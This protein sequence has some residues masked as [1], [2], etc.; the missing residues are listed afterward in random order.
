MRRSRL[1]RT[2]T[3]LACSAGLAVYGAIGLAAA[4]VPAQ[5]ATSSPATSPPATSPP[6]AHQAPIV[7]PPHVFEPYIGPS[8]SLTKTARAAGVKYFTL[9]FLQTAKPGSC[10]VDWNG[11]PR[12]PVGRPYA[13]GHRR[14]AGRAAARWC[15]SFG[16]ASADSD[17]DRAGRQLPQRARHRRGQYEKVITTYHLT[18]LDLDTEENSLNNYAGIDRRNKAYAM[19]ER[20]AAGDRAAWSSSCT[21]SRPTRPVSTRAAPYV[22]QNA[23]ANGATIADR[24]RDD[25]RLLRQPAARDRR[26]DHRGRR[27]PQLYNRAA[28]CCTRGKTVG[29]AVGD[30]RGHRGLGGGDDLGPAETLAPGRHPHEWRG[31]GD[32]PG[33][34]RVSCWNLGRTT[35]PPGQSREAVRVRVHPHP[36]GPF[37]SSV[38]RPRPMVRVSRALVG[39]RSR[40][41]SPRAATCGRCRAGEAS[42]CMAV[43]QYGNDAP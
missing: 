10:T 3:A 34:G 30:D 43:D 18:R 15:P 20:W 22:L 17:D 28:L 5:A 37:T 39:W 31:V 42:F 23:V 1:C 9:D 6:A 13:S 14:P 11:D 32:G 4:A 16:G 12:T 33:P 40:P 26:R 19:V 41:T 25:V 38:H 35:A 27:H 29:T 24:E 36:V 21:R 7:L 2:L 8:N